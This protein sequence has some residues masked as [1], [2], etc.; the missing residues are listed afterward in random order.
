MITL[1]RP[2]AL[3]VAITFCSFTGFGGCASIIHGGSQ[4][5]SF[6]SSPPGATVRLGNGM[7]FTAPKTVSL[8]RGKDQ[9][10]TFEKEGYKQEQVTITREFN[11]VPT[12]LGN[13]FWLVIGVVVDVVTGAAWSLE[14]ENV[15]VELEKDAPKKAA[16]AR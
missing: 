13:I 8:P 5:V 2:I 14:P 11:A 16:A 7:R 10:V 3:L 15:V 1:R 12:I 6:D 9:I 4:N